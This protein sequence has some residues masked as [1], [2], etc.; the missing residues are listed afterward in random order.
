MMNI[1]KDMAKAAAA[2]KKE[3]PEDDDQINLYATKKPDP[4]GWGQMGGI[5][6]YGNDLNK[7]PT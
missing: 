3:E 6:I 1:E 4:A 7:K 5:Q 2:E